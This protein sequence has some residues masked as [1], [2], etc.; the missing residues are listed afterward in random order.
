RLVGVG[1]VTVGRATVAAELSV[2]TFLVAPAGLGE[3][4]AE[5]APR[6]VLAAVFAAALP[7]VLLAAGST[8]FWT[9]GKRWD[10]ISAARSGAPSSAATGPSSAI[11]VTTRT[12]SRRS[13]WAAG[14]MRTARNGPPSLSEATCTTVPTGSPLG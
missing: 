10:R 7:A 9:L 1:G 8:G 2:A 3:G 11:L 4:L 14:L 13:R 6:L 12:S 5:V